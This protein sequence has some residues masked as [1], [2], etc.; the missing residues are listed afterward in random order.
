MEVATPDELLPAIESVATTV[1]LI[2]NTMLSVEDT[3][4]DNANSTND[5]LSDT[6]EDPCLAISPIDKINADKPGVV[7]YETDIGDS[8]KVLHSKG[9]F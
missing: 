9:E 2:M 1:G 8:C 3:A 5:P 4:S 7:E 6:T